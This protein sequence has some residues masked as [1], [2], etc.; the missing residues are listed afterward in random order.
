MQEA[1]S[2]TIAAKDL[3]I[4]IIQV[5]QYVQDVGSTRLEDGLDSGFQEAADAA[6][7]FDAAFQE[8]MKAFRQSNDQTAIDAL[9]KIRASFDAYYNLGVKMA[10]AYVDGGT[11]AGNKMMKSFD[12]QASE[13]EARVQPF[14]KHAQEVTAKAVDGIHAQ[15]KSQ[16]NRILAEIVTLLAM[17]GY[18]AYMAANKIVTPVSEAVHEMEAS[19]DY[20]MEAIEKVVILS[21]SLTAN[22]AAQAA[23]VNEASATVDSLASSSV[24]GAD[25]SKQGKV[26]AHSVKESVSEG[27]AELR[28]ALENLNHIKTA[29]NE[30]KNAVEEMQQ[31]QTEVTKIIKTIDGI[32][33]QTNLLALNAS[34]EAARAGEAGQGFAVVADEVRSLAMRS[35]EASRE[36]AKRIE[37]T[38]SIALKSAQASELLDSKIQDIDAQFTH[39]HEGF[40]KV[41]SRA[42]EFESLL[43][44]LS[45]IASEQ[46]ISIKEIKDMIHLLDTG[47]SE[48]AKN[49]EETAFAAK[50]LENESLAMLESLSDLKL[51]TDGVVRKSRY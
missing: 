47:T 19:V 17:A 4:A 14:L 40:E 1:L 22:A 25:R 10:H 6:K 24:A 51:V 30:M 45:T 11:S 36:T 33:F 34:V 42:S 48:C 37:A 23:R 49:C 21:D 43:E 18:M 35:T 28:H 41:S 8:L 7:A 3:E 31:S 20:S 26:I 12:A 15:N 16:T 44:S 5:Q 2:K 38:Q 46:S 27:Q 29:F 32:A 50:D 39:V 9:N 13:L